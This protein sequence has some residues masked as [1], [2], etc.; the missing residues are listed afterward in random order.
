MV[1]CDHIS[2]LKLTAEY[3]RSVESENEDKPM[4]EIKDLKAIISK[5]ET[6]ILSLKK[7]IELL[8]QEKDE[9]CAGYDTIP[10]WAILREEIQIITGDCR[11]SGGLGCV[12]EAVYHD[13]MVTVKQLYAFQLSPHNMKLFVRE[14]RILACLKHP[15]I[16]RFTGGV[17][18]QDGAPMI[19]MELM[20]TTCREIIQQ[21][22]NEDVLSIS[23]DVAL[24]LNHLHLIKPD[25]IIHHNMSSSNV[26]L[27]PS[28]PPIR[29]NV[30]L[31]GFGVACY[32][33]QSDE[34][35]PG[36]STYAAPESR[37][38]ALYS[39]K[40]DV[41]CYGVLLLELCTRQLPHINTRAEQL[42]ALSWKPMIGIIRPCLLEDPFKRPF[43]KEVVNS[44]THLDS[45]V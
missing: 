24:A 43:M 8:K 7:D 34:A 12:N 21:L 17:M 28:T 14:M 29:W 23:T 16:I 42:D 32:L 31:A 35:C 37:V 22:D 13:S 40:M 44:L 18:D 1:L 36:S 25:P 45:K 10:T 26:L 38:N 41:F 11:E 19:V 2:G 27:T 4:L 9:R 15:N 3:T 6:M 5:N 20:A 39:P 33:S 30:K